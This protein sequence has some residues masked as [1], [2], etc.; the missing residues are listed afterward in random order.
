MTIESLT[1]FWPLIYSSIQEF[2]NITEPHIEDA[3]VRNNVPI[4]LYLYS[5]LGLDRFSIKDFQ[6][7]D[8]FSNPEQFERLF[9]RLNV[10]G[11]IEPMS[12]GSFRVTEKARQAVRSLIHAGDVQLSDFNSV[13]DIDLKRLVTLLKQ[14]VKECSVTSE[15]PEKWAI[16]KRFRVANE[17]YPPIMQIREYLM[18]LLAY[19]DDSHLSASRPHFNEA[20]IVWIVLGSLWKG[21]AA[22]AEQM[23]EKMAFRGYEMEDYEIAVQAALELGW[24]EEA[25]RPDTFRLTGQGKRLREQAEHLTNEYFYASWSVLMQ[26]EMDELYELLAR[27]R[28]GLNGYRQPR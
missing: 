8:P 27:L 18:D 23:A 25:E 1:K 6:R 5:E 21:D 15:P 3:A 4:E 20:G 26:D 14:I 24:A 2:W 12:D 10:K 17:H 16:L 9:V 19:R 22:N 13:T 28:V 11:W 7:R